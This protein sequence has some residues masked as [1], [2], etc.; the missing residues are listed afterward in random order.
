[1]LEPPEG[2]T[3]RGDEKAFALRLLSMASKGGLSAAQK[4]LARTLWDVDR[5]AALDWLQK[6]SA[7]EDPEAMTELAMAYVEE[8]EAPSFERIVGL[9]EGAEALGHVEAATNLGYVYAKGIAGSPDYRKAIDWFWKAVQA[10]DMKAAINLALLYQHGL[11]TTPRPV[12]ALG[13]FAAAAC[14]APDDPDL[15]GVATGYIDKMSKDDIGRAI[16]ALLREFG[17]DPGEDPETVRQ[18]LLRYQSAKE[19][20]EEG[21]LDSAALLTLAGCGAAEGSP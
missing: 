3:V 6:A 2:L 18:A 13:L 15:N 11:G 9:L 8:G 1:M 7:Q 20:P 19:L 17:F 16:G 10:G 21:E 12:E 5:T 14:S 4:H